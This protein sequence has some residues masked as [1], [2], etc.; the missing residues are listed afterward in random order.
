LHQIQLL[1]SCGTGI[2]PVAQMTND[3][4]AGTYYSHPLK[5]WASRRFS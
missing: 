3:K 5:E 1:A 4:A 2:L